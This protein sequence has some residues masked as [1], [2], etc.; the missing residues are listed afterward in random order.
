MKKIVVLMSVSLIA[1][2]SYSFSIAMNAD[3]GL[4]ADQGNMYSDEVQAAVVGLAQLG[5]DDVVAKKMERISSNE[6]NPFANEVGAELKRKVSSDDALREKLYLSKQAFAERKNALPGQEQPKEHNF[7]WSISEFDEGDEIFNEQISDSA[8]ARSKLFNKVLQKGAAIQP[9][10]ILLNRD[11]Y[12][13]KPVEENGFEKRQKLE[14]KSRED[15]RQSREETSS[16]FRKGV[17]PGIKSLGFVQEASQ[18]GLSFKTYSTQDR[19]FKFGDWQQELNAIYFKGVEAINAGKIHAFE[20]GDILALISYVDYLSRMY[21]SNMPFTYEDSE[22]LLTAILVLYVR[23]VQDTHAVSSVKQLVDSLEKS[24]ILSQIPALENWKQTFQSYFAKTDLDY[25]NAAH[26]AVISALATNWSVRLLDALKNN[27]LPSYDAVFQ[28]AQETLKA[29]A[30]ENMPTPAVVCCLQGTKAWNASPALEQAFRLF[31][32][33]A[34]R[35]EGLDI[36]LSQLSTHG[37]WESF[38]QNVL[39][40]K[41][42]E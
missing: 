31:N 23:L 14:K 18:V 7:Q 25:S 10:G 40:I 38:M 42:S 6:S 13:L 1:L 3:Y 5:L 22:K 2:G 28:N 30:Q 41:I 16:L 9:K 4:P 11:G 24:N 39:G 37:N 17:T 33:E 35:Q 20:C 15:F 27:M 8:P 21:E 32:F 34:T 19:Q 36:A 26:E 12:S 29:I